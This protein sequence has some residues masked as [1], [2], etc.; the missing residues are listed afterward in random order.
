MQVSSSR[1]KARF[2]RTTTAALLAA[3]LVPTAALAHPHVFAEARLELTI[4]PDGTVQQ[5][6]H[7]WRFDDVFS[8]TVLMEFDKNG[9]LKLDHKELIDLG[10]VINESIAEFKYF[11]TVQEDAKDVAMVRP[12]DLAATF[13]DNRLL[14]VFTS[15]PAKPL[16]LQPG[17]KV[18]FGVYDPTF[19][20]AIDYVDDKELVVKGLPQG[21]KSTVVRPD[22]DQAIAQNQATLTEAFFNDPAGTDM[23]KIFATRLE[24]DCAA[25]G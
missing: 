21:C 20:T 4:A 6:A 15:K 22:P 16:K 3:G 18:S 9:D 24:I 2:A 7:V 10:H 19:Y 13:T 11:Q 17:H 12:N 25:K 8:S 23:S 14:I 5:L 1:F